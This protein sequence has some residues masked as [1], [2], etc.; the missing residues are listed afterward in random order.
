MNE[1]PFP[2][3]ILKKLGCQPVTLYLKQNNV[4][5]VRWVKIE[6]FNCFIMTTPHAVLKFKDVTFYVKLIHHFRISEPK[7]IVL[8]GFIFETLDLPKIILCKHE[9]QKNSYVSTLCHNLYHQ[10]F[11]KIYFHV[12]SK[13][14]L[15]PDLPKWMTSTVWIK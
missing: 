1:S 8:T 11:F 13:S 9:W 12:M 15:R 14:I 2:N 5:D 6:C 7:L 10:S 3:C 4:D